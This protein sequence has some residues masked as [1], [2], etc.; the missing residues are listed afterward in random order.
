MSKAS[1]EHV[2][3]RSP[4]QDGDHQIRALEDP[5]DEEEVQNTEWR[6]LAIILG[7][8]QVAIMVLYGLFVE[9]KEGTFGDK[10]QLQY[11]MYLDVTVMMLVG[12]G[13]LMT[14]QRQ[15]ALGA[16]G[17]TFMI[18]CICVTE[19]VL[20]GR[21]FASVVGNLGE[22][23]GITG[24][25]I[26]GQKS[27]GSDVHAWNMIQL[28]INALLQGTFASAAVLISFGALIG[29]ITPSQV[30][31]VAAYLSKN[32][33]RLWPSLGRGRASL[34]LSLLLLLLLVS[35]TSILHVAS[36]V[37]CCVPPP[38]PPSSSSALFDRRPS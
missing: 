19:C 29:K 37:S 8:F 27:N 9:Y 5:A 35:D 33:E 25:P 32:K 17:L 28:D 15:Y 23:P 10:D 30:G 7:A 20:T 34:L 38:P 36:D 21:F 11:I 18:T 12:F 14:F 4:L 3:M 6:R 1:Y 2:A 13:F 24:N 26:A 31:A 22:Y 16:V